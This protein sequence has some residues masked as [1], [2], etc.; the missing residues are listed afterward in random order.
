[1]LGSVL[2]VLILSRRHIKRIHQDNYAFR[3]GVCGKGFNEK[4]D[5]KL[6]VDTHSG[7]KNYKV[8]GAHSWVLRIAIVG[9]FFSPSLP[10]VE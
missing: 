9:Y 10:N 5:F 6:H 8:D 4:R 2:L 3:C 1:M 7:V